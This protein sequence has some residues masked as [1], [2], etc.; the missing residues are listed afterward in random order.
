MGPWIEHP[1]SPF[2]KRKASTVR[3]GGRVLVLDD[4]IVRYAQDDHPYYGHQVRA[5]RIIK[6]TTTSYEEEE[7]KENPIL[8]PGIAGWNNHGMHNI[9]PHQIDKNEW[10]ACVDGEGEVLVF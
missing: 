3:S 9:D 7:V 6:L 8:K 4:Q 10:I 5:F 1:K 2:V